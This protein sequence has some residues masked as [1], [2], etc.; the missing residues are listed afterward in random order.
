MKQ[1]MYSLKGG[2]ASQENIKRNV[3]STLMKTIF[4]DSLMMLNL[5]EL[6]INEIRVHASSRN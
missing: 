6:K 3:L 1:M 5:L 2:S 4:K